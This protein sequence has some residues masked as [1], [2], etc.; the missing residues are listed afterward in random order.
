MID[1]KIVT[2]SIKRNEPDVNKTILEKVAGDDWSE[3]IVIGINKKDEF[4]VHTNNLCRKD[5]LW[6]LEKAKQYTLGD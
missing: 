5:S 3:V 4:I 1:N 2:F 6:L